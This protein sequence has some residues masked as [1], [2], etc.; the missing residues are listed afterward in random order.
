M[1]N[2]LFQKKKRE[3]MTNV[4]PLP[5]TVKPINT[6]IPNT[7]PITFV[8][9]WYLLRSKFPP[10]KYAEWI[11]NFMSIVNNFN[12]VV[13]TDIQSLPMLKLFVNANKKIKLVVKPVEEFWT[14]KYKDHWIRNHKS[15][16]MAL[17]KVTD[18]EVNML[19]NEKIF[20]VK[21][22]VQNRYFDTEYYG[23]C[24]I[25]YF[26]NGID[27]TN[28]A[29]LTNW[30]N[31]NLFSSHA[32]KKH[33]H[34]GRVQNDSLIWQQ[35]ESDIINHYKHGLKSPPTNKYD[36]ICFSGGFFFLHK[37]LINLYANLYDKKLEYYFDNHFF[38]KDDQLI[39]MDIIFT[40]RQLFFIHMERNSHFNKWFMF[41]RL[42]L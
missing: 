27:D 22:A 6:T 40:N 24:D 39:V 28:S 1:W 25:G 4:I 34:Y 37:D 21:D 14:Y 38:I 12:L 19:W 35:L 42:L 15:S 7:N 5:N 26:R 23:W 17:H 31:H 16:L 2:F 20:F 13:Y 30:P 29:F 11:N 3:T 18:W 9:C 32:L 36:E 33:I 8:T 10:M 41:Q